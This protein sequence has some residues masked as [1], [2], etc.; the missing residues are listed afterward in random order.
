MRSIRDAVTNPDVLADAAVSQRLRSAFKKL[1]RAMI[2]M[3]RLGLGPTFEWVPSITGRVLVVHHTG[4]RSGNRYRTPLNYAV[5]DD[6]V[7]CLAGF[8]RVSDWY[9]NL[10]AA[11]GE[12][13]IWMPKGR[14]MC[15]VEEASDHPDRRELLRA[16]LRGSGV[17]AF[18]FGVPPTLPDERLDEL[19]RDYRLIRLTR[20]SPA[21]GPDR[22]GDLTWIWAIVAGVW[23]TRRFVR[24][25]A[26]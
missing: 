5:V 21:T 19:T 9:R 1:N 18:A 8:G 12:A 13:E 17:V 14:W 11:G 10:L 2:L 3:W 15:T 20:H 16:V 23:I 7:Y 25:R 24:R 6:A 22:P 26:A 4:R